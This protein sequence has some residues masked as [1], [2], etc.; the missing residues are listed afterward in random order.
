MGRIF[1]TGGGGFV[2]RGLLDRLSAAG[3]VISLQRTDAPLPPGVTGCRGD[4]R[5]PGPW[6]AHLEGCDTVV[7]LASVTGK[8]PARDYAEVIGHG[9]KALLDAAREAGVRRILHVSTIAVRFADIRHYPYARAKLRAEQAVRASGL[10]HVIVRPTMVF[11]RGSPVQ[12][13]LESLA[14]L[15]VTPVFDGGRARVQPIDVADLTSLFLEVLAADPF[16]GAIL[17]VGGPEVL[18]VRDLLARMRGAAGR[19]AGPMLSVPTAPLRPLLALLERIDHRLAPIT[20]GQLGSFRFDGVAEPN[21]LTLARQPGMRTI[22]AM[23]ETG[24]GP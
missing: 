3:D 17:E 10:G 6:R 8:A 2:G 19:R 16:A 7:H 23:L 22:T 21:A 1:V 13:G 18:S 9:T 12:A 4:L 14:R 24:A 5:E 11:G 20:V 15:P